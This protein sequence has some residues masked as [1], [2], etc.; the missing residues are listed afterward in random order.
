MDYAAIRDYINT[1]LKAYLKIP[2]I[3]GDQVGEKPEYPFLRTKFTMPF[4]PEFPVPLN[5]P[6][7]F[8]TV[9]SQDP[10]WEYDVEITRRTNPSMSLSITA[11][12]LDE[13]Q[14]VELAIKA[15]NWF[16]FYAYDDLRSAGIVVAGIG[17]IHNRD[18][19]IV[20][21][22][23][24]RQGFDVTLQVRQELKKTVP[25]IEGVE[26]DANL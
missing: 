16:S 19:L 24:R 14:A 25:T 6:E 12:A 7:T 15:H 11:Y 22:Y 8:E 1:Q 20:G 2:V 21:D 5:A 26:Y 9:P 18:T 13:D 10:N 23:E 17:A 3:I 4:N